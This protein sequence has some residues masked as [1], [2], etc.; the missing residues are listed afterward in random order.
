M[1]KLMLVIKLM[2]KM[3]LITDKIMRDKTPTLILTINIMIQSKLMNMIILSFKFKTNR[4]IKW[5]D[6]KFQIQDKN[7]EFFQL[8]SKNML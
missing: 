7:D 1:I 8:L 4:K 6:K 5:I 2:N 3:H